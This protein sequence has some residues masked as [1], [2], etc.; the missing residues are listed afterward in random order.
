M[1]GVVDVDVLERSGE[2][3]EAETRDFDGEGVAARRPSASG[4]TPATRV[5]NRSHGLSSKYGMFEALR[6][7]LPEQHMAR[8]VQCDQR[9]V[10]WNARRTVSTT[11][12]QAP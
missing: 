4:W 8:F 3:P 2:V 6:L 5:R 10:P 9:V 11:P 12:E 1:C 7:Q